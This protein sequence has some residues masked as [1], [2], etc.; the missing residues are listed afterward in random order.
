M[1]ELGWLFLYRER[2]GEE[3]NGKGEEE[4]DGKEAREGR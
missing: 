2:G 1:E 3:R 4:G